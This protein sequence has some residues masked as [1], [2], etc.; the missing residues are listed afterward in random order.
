MVEIRPVHAP[1]RRAPALD[2]CQP[3]LR[4]VEIAAAHQ[5]ADLRVLDLEQVRFEAAALGDGARLGR[6]RPRL[7]VAPA[8]EV[9]ERQVRA[10]PDLHQRRRVGLREQGL[11]PRHEPVRRGALGVPVEVVEQ[12]RRAHHPHVD[13][14]LPIEELVEPAGAAREVRMP[15]PAKEQRDQP[16][17]LRAQFVRGVERGL[18]VGCEQA[19]ELGHPTIDGREVGPLVVVAD[20]DGVQCEHPAVDVAGGAERVVRVFQRRARALGLQEDPGA[21]EPVVEPGIGAAQRRRQRFDPVGQRLRAAVAR[22]FPCVRL[23]EPRHRCPVVRFAV[24][25][26]CRD[27]FAARLEQPGRARDELA[28]G[29]GGQVPA[30]LLEQEFAEQ[31]VVVVD[32]RLAAAPVDEQVAAIEVL[33]QP[34]HVVVAGERDR[35]GFGHRRQ[36]RRLHQR[37][38]V[39]G[40]R[41][42]EDLAGEVLEDRVAPFAE[43]LLERRAGPGEMLAQQDQCRDPALALALDPP[44]DGGVERVAIE[45]GGGLLGRAAQLRRLDPRDAPAG[46]KAREL[47]RRRRAGEHDHADAFGD[48]LQALRERRA[49]Q[50]G[51]ARLVE[52]VEHDQRVRGQQGEELAAERAREA[53][54]VLLPLGGEHRQRRSAVA[55]ELDR[56]QA[57]VMEERRRVAVAGVDVVPQVRQAPRLDVARDQRRLAGS[58]WGRDPDHRSPAR[59][60]ETREEA[61]SRHR[62]KEPGTRQFGESGR[63]TG[64][65]SWLLEGRKATVDDQRAGGSRRRSTPLGDLPGWRRL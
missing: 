39:V 7:V 8:E 48:L 27:G 56:R 58:R 53:R 26:E 6:H 20:D 33:E 36:D 16:R 22:P 37:A 62:V 57:Q 32:R 38:A 61:R 44:H 13:V 63:A 52:V 35:L 49:L 19:F 64:Q 28:P 50:C 41:A 31:R 9:P 17:R 14:R 51:G 2:G 25:G 21:A 3:S 12:H 54:Q 34:R 4:F 5:V 10:P 24:E 40:A 46:R 60:V 18:A 59:L 45:Q 65:G 1:A 47:G 43:G 15:G 55:D 11:D 23:D 42:A 30:P 29:V